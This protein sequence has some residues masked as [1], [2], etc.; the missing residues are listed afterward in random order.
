MQE[1]VSEWLSVYV[2][3]KTWF[4]PVKFRLIFRM[5]SNI[6]DDTPFE[7]IWPAYLIKAP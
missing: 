5:T 1:G 2:N 4:S 3:Q 6:D 7:A